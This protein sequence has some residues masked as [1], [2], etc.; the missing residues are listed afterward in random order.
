M[1]GTVNEDVFACDWS[2]PT[3]S[4]N[5]ILMSALP[6]LAAEA[7]SSSHFVAA[8]QLITAA[9]LRT[10]RGSAVPGSLFDTGGAKARDFAFTLCETLTG[11]CRRVL[12][13]ALEDHL[14]RFNFRGRA[15]EGAQTNA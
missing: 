1:T 8:L 14:G 5:S 7:A 9:G 10:L 13:L 3:Q 15:F 2:M 12:R 6:G 4:R 11:A